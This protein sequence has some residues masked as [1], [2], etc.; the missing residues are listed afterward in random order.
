MAANDPFNDVFDM[1]F[2]LFMATLM[3]AVLFVEYRR[4]RNK[5]PQFLPPRPHEYLP[6][7]LNVPRQREQQNIVED[8]G[9]MDV[10][11]AAGGEFE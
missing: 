3:L 10:T 5:Q 9:Y 7:T 6:S 4:N 8:V 1:T 11:D 2:L